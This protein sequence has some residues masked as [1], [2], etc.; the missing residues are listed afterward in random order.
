MAMASLTTSRWVDLLPAVR[1]TTNFTL[2]KKHHL[3]HHQLLYGTNP[4]YQWIYT[5]CM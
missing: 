5:C 2:S 4:S 3:L 1:L